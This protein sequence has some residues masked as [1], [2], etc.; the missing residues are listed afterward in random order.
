MDHRRHLAVIGPLQ[1][2]IDAERA[3]LQAPVDPHRHAFMQLAVAP[4]DGDRGRQ[5]QHVPD[6]LHPGADPDHHEVA[7]DA[8]AIGDHRLD[9]AAG[10]L[11]EA[12]H[13]DAGDDAHALVLRLPGQAVDRLGVVGVAAAL[14]VQHRGDALGLPVVE[15]PL[16]VGHAVGLALDEHRFVA[17]VLLLAGDRGDVLVH[18]LGAD[19]HVADRVVAEGGRVALPYR[20][21]VRHQAAHRRLEVVVADDAAGDARGTGG[22]R[23]LVEHQDVPAAAQPAPAQV[24]GEVPG[25]AE[26]VDAGA[27]DD[28]V[29]MRRKG[30]GGT[31]PVRMARNFGRPSA[32]GGLDGTRRTFQS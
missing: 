18:H 9:R 32:A 8:A 29:D 11:V 25:G 23:R 14:L 30:H 13:L 28:I 17:D 2:R 3:F 5:L 1:H 21:A 4:L 19:L 7:V 16:H 6:L 22:D 27:D 24:L 20:D 12:G 10:I 15:Q 26:A 31:F